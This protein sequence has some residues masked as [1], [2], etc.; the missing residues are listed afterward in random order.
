MLYLKLWNFWGPGTAWN[1]VKTHKRPQI[2][3][4]SK[5]KDILR[6]KFYFSQKLH[7]ILL[8]Y[9]TSRNWKTSWTN[10]IADK[11]R[12]ACCSS[13]KVVFVE[14]WNERWIQPSWMLLWWLST[15]KDW[16]CLSFI[17]GPRKTWNKP[18]SNQSWQSKYIDIS[19]A[20]PACD[21]LPR[22]GC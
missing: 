14:I 21:W 19:F 17:I 22:V 13:V 3:N 9:L 6:K 7:S 12:T 11:R 18:S 10:L 20:A 15:A 8:F 16:L 1:V 2:R 4:T 5:Q